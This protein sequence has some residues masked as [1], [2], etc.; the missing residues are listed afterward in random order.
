MITDMPRYHDWTVKDRPDTYIE[1]DGL[2][3]SKKLFVI[4]PYTNELAFTGDD[5]YA[6]KLEDTFNSISSIY[7]NLFYWITFLHF[8]C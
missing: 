8:F 2:Y 6:K 4:D 3:Y 1:K 7:Y 5:K